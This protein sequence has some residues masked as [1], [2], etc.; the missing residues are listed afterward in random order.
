MLKA[1]VFAISENRRLKRQVA[2]LEGWRD[3]AIA[4]RN[5]NDRYEALAQAQDRAQRAHGHRP[6]HTWT[7]AGPSPT[8][9]W[10]TLA[11]GPGCRWAIRR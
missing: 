3:T 6:H 7:C 1:T 11:R 5:V 9:G 4:L 8:R 2:E 10:W